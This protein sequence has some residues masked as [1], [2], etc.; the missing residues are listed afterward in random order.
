MD[1]RIVQLMAQIYAEYACVEGMKA[2]NADRISKG[3]ALA[4]T[5]KDFVDRADQLT[6]LA[7]CAR[8]LY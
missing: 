6:Y 8:N 7:E 3:L 2:E 1:N 5:E 4:Y